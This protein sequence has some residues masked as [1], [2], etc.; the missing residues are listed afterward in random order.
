MDKLSRVI[1]DAMSEMYNSVTG[2]IPTLFI[3]TQIIRIN[4]YL[5]DFAEQHNSSEFS[6]NAS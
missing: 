1:N 6:S 5:K 4:T 2:S 3:S